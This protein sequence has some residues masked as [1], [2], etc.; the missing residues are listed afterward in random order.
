MILKNKLPEKNM[1]PMKSQTVY[2][3]MK[4]CGIKI[5]TVFSVPKNNNHNIHSEE[6]AREEHVYH[7]KAD[8]ILFHEELR[9]KNNYSIF[10]TQEQQPHHSQ[11]R[12]CS[13]RT[14]VPWKGSGILFHEEL[15]DKNNY[16]IFS[17]QEQQ[18]YQKQREGTQFAYINLNPDSELLKDI[19]LSLGKYRQHASHQAST[20]INPNTSTRK[21]DTV[22]ILHPFN[23]NTN[24]ELLQY[25]SLSL[26]E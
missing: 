18:V 13:R 25:I 4:N 9:D 20:L 14:R 1:C 24:S 3:F 12:S 16:N 6:A 7:E 10:S 17:T 8:G 11:R 5:A 21:V 26:G 22:L 15:W 23:L 19:Y 2:Y